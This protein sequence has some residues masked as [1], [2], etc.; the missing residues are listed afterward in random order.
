MPNADSTYI[1][2]LT[3][4]QLRQRIHA[5]KVELIY[6]DSGAEA[7]AFAI[8]SLVDPRDLR[9]VRYVGQTGSPV[10]RWVQHVNTARLWLPDERPWWVKSSELRPLYT[11][12][13]ELH[14]D[15]YRLPAMIITHW[16]PSSTAAQL[17]ERRRIYECLQL[18]MNLLNV[19]Q[20]RLHG[21][22]ILL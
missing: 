6:D 4:T 21:Q 13:R 16:E 12:I 5:R 18:Q 15:D 9:N 7:D 2:P 1:E 14:R 17:M 11:W 10:R 19:E 20:E 22:N 8:Y 3:P